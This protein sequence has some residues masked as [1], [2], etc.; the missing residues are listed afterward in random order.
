MPIRNKGYY[1]D[2]DCK[3]FGCE[4]SFGKNEAW[5]ENRLKLEAEN[6]GWSIDAYD[7]SACLNCTKNK[8]DESG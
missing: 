2:C 6:A 3:L 5:S 8:K 4:V 1:V 7:L